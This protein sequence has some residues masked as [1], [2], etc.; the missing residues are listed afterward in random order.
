MNLVRRKIFGFAPCIPISSRTGL[1][2]L[3]N[4]LKAARD[5]QTS[6]TR[7]PPGIGPAMCAST[8][9]TGHGKPLSS[10]FQYH[11]DA[12]FVF[13]PC[14]HAAKFK[15]DSNGHGISPCSGNL[16]SL[17]ANTG[18][19]SSTSETGHVRCNRPCLLRAN[20]G[21]V[22]NR[23]ARFDQRISASTYRSS[24][25]RGGVTKTTSKPHQ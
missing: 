13:S 17:S 6:I 5:C 18:E 12:F 9:L 25:R 16:E 4:R 11:L 21:H 19:C 10:S 1:S 15:E 2:F 3:P 20:S 7:Q 23:Y 24:N 8:P 14:R 22:A